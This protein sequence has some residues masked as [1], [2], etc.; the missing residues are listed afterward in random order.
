MTL[1]KKWDPLNAK[2]RDIASGLSENT[3]AKWISRLFKLERTTAYLAEFPAGAA[4][5]FFF[6]F[7]A[8]LT[9]F[10]CGAAVFAATAGA[11]EVLVVVAVSAAIAL[12]ANNA[13]IK[14]TI[15]FIKTP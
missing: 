10:P 3:K 7:L 5:F 4:A 14:V 13:A 9:V 12:T 2:S 15:I 1:S 8:F 11:E 6:F